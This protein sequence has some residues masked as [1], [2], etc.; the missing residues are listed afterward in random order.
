M[1][2]SQVYT[3]TQLNFDIS[4]IDAHFSERRQLYVSAINTYRYVSNTEMILVKM[5][6]LTFTFC[7]L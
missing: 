6:V 4:Y 1:S 2:F 5:C 7:A 3:S